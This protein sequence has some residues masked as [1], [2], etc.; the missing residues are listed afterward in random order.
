MHS[1]AR[2]RGATLLDVVVGTGLMLVVFVGIVGAFRLTVNA[3]GNNSARAGAIALANERL[4]FVRS[5]DYDD[6]GTDG[7]IPSGELEQTESIVLN[8][9]N[10][11]RRTFVSYEDDPADG[12]GVNDE[13]DIPTDYKAV[14]TSVSWQSRQGTRTVTMV[15]RVS[16]VGIE[17]AVPGGTLVIQVVNDADQPV[18]NAEVEIVNDSTNPQIDTTTYTD[19]DGF[20]TI[21]GAPAGANYE[22]SVTKSGYSTAQTYDADAVNTNPIPAHISV[23]LNQ[24][25]LSTFEIDLVSTLSVQ[26]FEPVEEETWDDLFNN[27]T[28]LDI[29]EDVEVLGGDIV[30]VEPPEGYGPSG[31]ARSIAITPQYL[32][33]WRE[34]SW[35]D[36]IPASTGIRYHLFTDA[37]VLVPDADLPGNNAGFDVSPV[38]LTL[39]TTT[40]P[41]LR[42]GAVLSTSDASSTP[43]VLSWEISYET[44]P[45]PLPNVTFTM[46]GAKTIGSGPAG[47]VYKYDQ[48]HS[49]GASGSISIGQVEYDTYTLSVDASSGYDIS[50]SCVPQPTVVVPGSSVSSQLFLSPHT[51]NALLVDVRAA[52]GALIPGASVRLQRSG[53]D[54]TVTSDICGQ[55]FFSDIAA[56]GATPYSIEVSAAGYQSYSSSD[57][58]VTGTTRLSVILNN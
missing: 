23:A 44:G 30:L 46:Q 55:T 28:K 19:D 4:E 17:T 38:T 26:T 14:K 49:S 54:E 42:V 50:S 47:P 6:I 33:A 27:E 57:V 25:T 45:T 22:I 29:T 34:F 2:E 35:E 1:R 11:T 18:V 36:D 39:S 10:Y 3:V 20:A 7:G 16:P 12:E 52:G 58:G 8:N 41:T 9:T 24:T 13:N 51:T 53:Y 37:G 15:A 43:A 48:D 21:L 32:Y 40:Y 5:L 31:E 56:S